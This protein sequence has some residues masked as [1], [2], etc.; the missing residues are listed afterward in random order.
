MSDLS[1]RSAY[2]RVLD[3]ECLLPAAAAPA[4]RALLR[5]G[6]DPDDNLIALRANASSWAVEQRE[7]V[8]AVLAKAPDLA[9]RESVV[10]RALLACAPLSLRSGAWLQWL[11]SM[12]TAESPP[13]LKVLAAYA[14]DLGVGGPHASRADA[15]LTVMRSRRLAAHASPAANLAQ[16]Q[17]VQEIA[18]EVPTVLL[19][20]GRLPE[21]FEAE[22][23]GADLCLRSVGLLP[24]LAAAAAELNS[25]QWTRIDPASES[26]T[27]E[28]AL[29]LA[30]A[31]TDDAATDESNAARMARVRLGFRWTFARLREWHSATYDDLVATVDPGHD[32]AELIAL[33]SREGAI[34]HHGFPVG[35]HD[36]GALLRDGDRNPGALLDALAAS[37]VVKPGNAGGSSLVNGLL[38]E[39]GPMFRVFAEEDVAVMVRWING[40]PD[41]G[42]EHQWQPPERVHLGIPGLDVAAATDAAPDEPAPRDLREAYTRL[43]TRGDSPSLRAWAAAYVRGWLARSA[44][45][46]DRAQL[47]LPAEWTPAG[48]RPWLADE[49]DR[50][51]R[52]FDGTAEAELP[53]REALVD[54]TIQLGPLTMIDGAWLQ[55]FTDLE[56][57]SSS[58]GFSLFETFWD[59][60][61]NG[62]ASLNHPLI[63]RALLREMGAD[64]PPTG[65]PAFAQWSGF[66]DESFELPVYWLCLGRFPRTHQPEVL[67]MNLA[68]E[69]S[70]VG[71]SY[72][73][74]RLSLKEHGF[75]TRFVDIHN[76]IDNVASGHSAWA[77]DA[78]DTYMSALTQGE[79]AAVWPRIRIGFRSLTPPDT[80]VARRLQRASSR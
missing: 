41:H 53:G 30:E 56:L 21:V 72:R 35:G 37:K 79:Q 46:I 29:L 64:L 45:R 78:I 62:Q 1:V 27:G 7:R 28:P 49:H 52:D 80:F 31:L 10:R 11:S 59:E 47:S 69:L 14:G 5:A 63:Y 23:L 22:V 61:G 66:R 77:A 12:A 3:P 38:A 76:T 74:A 6:A 18:F 57:A 54:A 32:M 51:D 60:L 13:T 55:G 15:Y 65:D 39:R 36:L 75:S 40:L 26:A 58:V 20:L 70:G 33:R 8:L 4:L 73:R 68:M 48:L 16:D 24:A 50:H 34:Y 44:H 17:R 2:A 19:A 9:A 43:L 42:G 71:G 67:G 25:D